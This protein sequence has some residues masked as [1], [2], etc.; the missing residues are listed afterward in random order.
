M[1]LRAIVLQPQ[2]PDGGEYHVVLQVAPPTNDRRPRLDRGVNAN[3][4]WLT[5]E[6]LPKRD[7]D[8]YARLFAAAPQLLE[9]CQAVRDFIAGASRLS[10]A[11]V[12][13]GL[14]MLAGTLHEAIGKAEGDQAKPRAKCATIPRT[15][16]EKT[17]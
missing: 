4:G 9:A 13:V 10:A 16:P 2:D 11:N 7:V 3:L 6:E 17:Q 15:S 8:A 1:S 14:G 12:K 5:D